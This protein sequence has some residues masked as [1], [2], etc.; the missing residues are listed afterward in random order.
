[1]FNLRHLLL[2]IGFLLTLL[3]PVFAQQVVQGTEDKLTGWRKITSYTS[4]FESLM[5]GPAI[6]KE[7]II[8]ENGIQ[9]PMRIFEATADFGVYA[10]G[11]IDMSLVVKS[12][13]GSLTPKSRELFFE[14]MFEVAEGAMVAE[15]PSTMRFERVADTPFNGAK[16]RLYLI[17]LFGNT[18]GEMRLLHHKDRVFLVMAM[19]VSDDRPTNLRRFN[20]SIR[21]L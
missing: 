19:D 12:L 14:F 5:P 15:L 3:S 21:F 11:S 4:G 13:E 7:E 1:M 20:S 18:L 8:T 9:M 16:G 17:K 10:V 2:T 6:L